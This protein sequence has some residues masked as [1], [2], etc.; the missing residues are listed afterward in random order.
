MQR[1]PAPARRRCPPRS[2]DRSALGC[3]S[4]NHSLGADL[5]ATL[6]SWTAESSIRPSFASSTTS[7]SD[8]S[9]RPGGRSVVRS[10]PDQYPLCRPPVGQDDRDPGG[11]SAR[12]ATG[13]SSTSSSPDKKT[14]WRNFLGEGGPI[15]LLKLDGAGPHRPRA[16]PTVTTH[17]RVDGDRSRLRLRPRFACGGRAFRRRAGSG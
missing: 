15:T 4:E 2:A 1:A 5:G 16:S 7:S 11:L 17:G 8:S 9:T 10:R 12:P 3:K 14:W 6:G 13:S